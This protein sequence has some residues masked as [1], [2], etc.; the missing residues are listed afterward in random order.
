MTGFA[1]QS[2]ALRGGDG[3]PPVDAGTQEPR[4]PLCSIRRP[5]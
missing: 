2:M 5:G 3:M 1:K 4:L